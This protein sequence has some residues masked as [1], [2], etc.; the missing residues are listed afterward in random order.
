MTPASG[1]FC[2]II[3]EEDNIKEHMAKYRDIF[4]TIP[5]FKNLDV[6][7]DIK[8]IR[9]VNNTNLAPGLQFYSGWLWPC[10]ALIG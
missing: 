7:S 8:D 2:Q 6:K 1:D 10:C 9:K 3:A 5:E 4:C